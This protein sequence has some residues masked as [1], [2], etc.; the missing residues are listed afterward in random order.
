ME[1]KSDYTL[2]SAPENTADWETYHRIRREELFEARGRIG[3]YDAN[4]AEE[5]FPNHFSL[6][7]KYQGRAIGTTRLDVREDGTAIVRLVAIIKNEQRKGHGSELA[8]CVEEIARAKGV[9]KLLVNAVPDAVGY[10]EKLGYVRDDWDPNE[11]TGISA[12]SIQM[13]KVLN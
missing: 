6:L 2:V 11:L 13:S 4:R 7:F 8:K 3:I 5:K 12:N 1:E 10:Y 9:Q